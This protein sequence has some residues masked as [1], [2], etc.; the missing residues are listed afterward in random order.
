MARYVRADHLTDYLGQIIKDPSA[1]VR[2]EAAIA[3]KYIGSETAAKL[4]ADLALK[5]QAGDRWELEALGIGAD[6]FPDLYFEAW[7]NKVGGKWNDSAGQD[8]IWRVKAKATVPLLAKLIQDKS[9]SADK[10][11][12]YF[13]A[14]HFKKHPQ[15]DEILLSLLNIDHPQ[16][17]MIKIYAVGQ[18]D[19]KFVHDSESNINAVKMVLPSIEG[20]SEWLM[21][22]Q[23][24][25]IKG[26][27]KALFALITSD[28]DLA[29]R[30]E[31]AG[32]LFDWDGG[33]I[34]SDYLNS[35][36]NETSKLQVIDVLGGVRNINALNFLEK[37]VQE[38]M[39]TF[40]VMRKVVESLGNTLAGQRKLFKLLES[41]KVKEEHK[42]T[43]VLKLMTSWDTKIKT[44]APKY[45][46]SKEN[47]KTDFTSLLEIEGNPSE[48]ELV[49][50]I[51]CAS[52][53]VAGEKGSDFGPNLSDIGNKL[54]RSFL[55]SSIVYP[56]EGINFGY[57]GYNLKLK[58]G[59]AI[60]GYII[61][62]TENTI[63]LK[64]MG[65]TIKEVSVK[66]IEEI[67]AMNQSLMPEGLDEVMKKQDLVNLV[68]YLETLKLK[69]Q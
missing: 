57:E 9:I 14:F 40:P 8:I 62:R 35:D 64:M 47:K 32:L 27:E 12:S 25:K 31:A 66:D 2:R 23:N 26:Q 52:C 38:D 21:V 34:V 33:E 30:K 41:G 50:D 53:H 17:Q 69:L 11:P 67:V 46:P 59:S 5:H 15:K 48:G 54:S 29:L 60:M 20:T 44:E 19:E 3:L 10:I 36:A 39:F 49:Y 42:T 28:A 58:D 45:L 43:A 13:R 55:Y 56:S 61:G 22:I 24:L 18:L 68:S 4:W 51:Y 63:T 65:A 16:K 6:Q 1:Q 37:S 7:K